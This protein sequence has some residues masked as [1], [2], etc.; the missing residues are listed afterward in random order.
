MQPDRR[1]LWYLESRPWVAD[2]DGALRAWLDQHYREISRSELG[3]VSVM[4]YDR[5]PEQEK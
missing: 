1:Y 3:G 2:P 5:H 4:L